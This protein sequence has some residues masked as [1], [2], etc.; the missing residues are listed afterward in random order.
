VLT[1]LV[2]LLHLGRDDKKL[3]GKEIET[4]IMKERE[5]KKDREEERRE[6]KKSK[7]NCD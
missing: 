2:C 6:E 3:S 5:M 1:K 4:L 7:E